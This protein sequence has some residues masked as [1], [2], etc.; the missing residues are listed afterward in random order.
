MVGLPVTVPLGGAGGCFALVSSRCLVSSGLI[1][2]SNREKTGAGSTPINEFSCPFVFFSNQAIVGDLTVQSV[3]NLVDL[4]QAEIFRRR[5]Q[6]W[7]E[8]LGRRRAWR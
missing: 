8:R 6:Y 4:L 7:I 3:G 5:R 2:A 1:I